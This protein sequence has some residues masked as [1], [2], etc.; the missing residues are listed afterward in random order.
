MP[1]INHLLQNLFS[2]KPAELGQTYVESAVNDTRYSVVDNFD[3]QT[4]ASQLPK[5]APDWLIRDNTLGPYE[6]EVLNEILL[7]D[8]MLFAYRGGAGSGKS[9]LANALRKRGEILSHSC[10]EPNGSN[11]ASKTGV[12]TF[13]AVSNFQSTNEFS[14]DAMMPGENQIEQTDKF[15]LWAADLMLDA[16]VNQ[17]CNKDENLTK[18]LAYFVDE[19]DNIHDYIDRVKG[20]IKAKSGSSYYNLNDFRGRWRKACKGLTGREQFNVILYLTCSIS[21]RIR[22]LNLKHRNLQSSKNDNIVLCLDNTDRI[23]HDLLSSFLTHLQALAEQPQYNNSGLKILF[24]VRLSTSRDIMGALPNLSV[25]QFRSPDPQDI[26]IPKIIGFLYNETLVADIY[27]NDVVFSAKTRLLEFIIRINDPFDKIYDLIFSISGTNIRIFYKQI[28]KLIGSPKFVPR[29][30]TEIEFQAYLPRVSGFVSDI[31]FLRMSLKVSG[32]IQSVLANVQEV[33]NGNI[34]ALINEAASDS[35]SS[36]HTLISSQENSGFKD[37]STSQKGNLFEENMFD[38]LFDSTLERVIAKVE[39]IK[40][41]DDLPKYKSVRK[42]IVGINDQCR[43]MCADMDMPDSYDPNFVS[44][45]IRLVCANLLRVSKEK[46]TGN[47]LIFRRAKLRY[48]M[49]KISISS[50]GKSNFPSAKQTRYSLTKTLLGDVSD[51]VPG[52]VLP[53]NLFSAN[54]IVY[55]PIPLKMVYMLGCASRLEE[56]GE[57]VP[58]INKLRLESAIKGQGHTKEKFNEAVAATAS[59]DNRL[60]YSSILNNLAIANNLAD[61]IP[62]EAIVNLSWSGR[63]YYELLTQNFHYIQWCLLHIPDLIKEVEEIDVH[64]LSG[65]VLD[66]IPEFGSIHYEGLADLDS[67]SSMF[68]FWAL[69]DHISQRRRSIRFQIHFPDVDSD[70]GKE[71]VFAHSYP[72]VDILMRTAPDLYG[73]LQYLKRSRSET[74]NVAE[75]I[76]ANLLSRAKE[77]CSW[78]EAESGNRVT[79]WDESL[80]LMVH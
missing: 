44:N 6:K 78:A 11:W 40:F 58:A 1:N 34:E 21:R 26:V 49:P 19:N 67:T 37:S 45:F 50:G 23:R 13:F 30:N 66:A 70:I 5:E 54:E 79:S 38:E 72:E 10:I 15:F 12:S 28:I 8:E 2:D 56:V 36:L 55:E 14:A 3:F 48:L 41:E 4:V 64:K 7:S 39:A 29:F 18:V 27:P 63:R 59:K 31:S 47:T 77:I 43:K 74:S 16:F 60:I 71:I 33:S 32:A 22:T 75:N 80:A 25:N 73:V 61:T 76:Q 68:A 9:S 57:H 52:D 24:F 46:S 35:I 53:V 42:F 20:R 69:L 62:N 51:H 65:G 17:L